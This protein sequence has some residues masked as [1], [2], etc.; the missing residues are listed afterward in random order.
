MRARDLRYIVTLLGVAALYVLGGKLGL[1]LALINASASSVWP[2]SGIAIAALL[3]YGPSAWPAVAAG[4]F[5][6]NV[7]TAGGPLAA[8]GIAAGNTLEAVAAA[9][10]VRRY[11]N[12]A[13]AFDRVV[14]VFRFTLLAAVA[15]TT[16]SATTGTAT[17]FLTGN[18]QAERLLTI[19]WTWWLGDAGG[20]VI[21]APLLL[22][23]LTPPAVVT[24][25][26]ALPEIL[27]LS[28][29]AAATIVVVFT[30][31]SPLAVAHV[32]IAYLTF[33]AIAWAAVRFG[34]R[35][36]SVVVL[37]LSA[38]AVAGVALGVGPWVGGDENATLLITLGFMGTASVTALALTAAVIER[39]R[40]V[41]AL[42]ATEV[43]L[44]Q[45]E[46]DKVAARDEFLSIA[47]HELRTPLTALRLA[48]ESFVREVDQGREV[49]PERLRTLAALVAERSVRLAELVAHLLDTVRIQTG[50]A[51]DLH[52]SEQDMLA[53]AS[54]V[55]TETQARTS[56]HRI[57]VRGTPPIVASV[58]PLRIEQV[59][60]NLLDNAVKFSP[61]GEIAIDVSAD[62][63]HIEL[64]VRDH[65]PGI[66]AEHRAKIFDRFYQARG[67]GADGLGLGL[68]LSRHIVE[69][70]GGTIAAE[71]PGDGGTA[72]LVRLPR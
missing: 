12:G 11:A 53:L 72:I 3:M 24:P 40:S 18:A 58:D 31:L 66:P 38:A 71:F 43:L 7:T 35:S 41:R 61:S 51:D 14:D 25:W 10:L 59:V 67:N 9:Y 65:G 30:P 69:L 2:P 28:A 54:R 27:A 15:A 21:V 22:V 48:S 34:P 63:G 33:P 29:L 56:R 44:R 50:R 23:W 32:P 26:S 57:E 6:V 60:R 42:H 20:A 1:S 17:L 4:A 49:R 62:D 64:R 5:V 47:A 39:E 13:R 8:I 55:A 19:W 70:H 68:H 45:A 46:E 16:I 37:A 36:S 52:R